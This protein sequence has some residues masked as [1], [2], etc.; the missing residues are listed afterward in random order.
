M[1][2][3][4]QYNKQYSRHIRWSEEDNCWVCVVP[5]LPGCQADGGTPQEVWDNAERIIKE[6]KDTAKQLGRDIPKSAT[7]KITSRIKRAVAVKPMKNYILL[8]KFDNGEERIYNC[9]KLLQNKMFAEIANVGYFNT[10]HVD[11]MGIVCWS[12]ALDISPFELYDNSQKVE[13]FSF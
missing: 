8:V 10:V 2:E 5:E 1:G 6:W 4:N 11:D 7:L 3:D 13:E 12:D 9:Y